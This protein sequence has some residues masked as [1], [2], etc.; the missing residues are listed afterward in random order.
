MKDFNWELL[1]YFISCHIE[2][3]IED[4]FFI[5]EDRSYFNLQ[6]TYKLFEDKVFIIP[7]PIRSIDIGTRRIHLLSFLEYY[8]HKNIIY[9]YILKYKL[10]WNLYPA[11][12]E[13]I[14]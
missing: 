7:T 5:S 11:I 12:M 4:I 10:E 13:Y 3:N 1:Q 8:C 6:I 9:G 2:K 14:I